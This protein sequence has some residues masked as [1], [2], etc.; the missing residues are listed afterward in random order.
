MLAL[1]ALDRLE[2]KGQTIKVKLSATALVLILPSFFLS[3]LA[4]SFLLSSFLLNH[5]PIFLPLFFP[6]YFSF[7]SYSFCL[8]SFIL[9]F[10]FL[11]RQSFLDSSLST[12][13][14]RFIFLFPLFFS[15]SLLFFSPLLLSPYFLLFNHLLCLSSFPPL[16]SHLFLYSFLLPVSFPL[17]SLLPS[18][19]LPGGEWTDHQ[20]QTLSSY[21]TTSSF[22]IPPFFF[23]SLPT[24]PPFSSQAIKVA[25]VL[26]PPFLH[27]PS[28]WFPC[29]S[30][31]PS[32]S[33][34][35]TWT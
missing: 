19:Q 24:L 33:P 35:W 6:F 10:L 12:F 7:I 13:P 18:L 28:F 14:P 31:D 2:V 9:S 30:R 4:V 25:L 5:L 8:S 22:Y 23:L 26:S 11:F 1:S 34:R 20:G 17:F 3:F 15:P 32:T 21:C 29:R 27:P 16:S